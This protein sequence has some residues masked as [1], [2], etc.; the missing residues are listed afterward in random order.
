MKIINACQALIAGEMRSNVAITIQENIITEIGEAVDNPDDVV[1]GTLIPGFVD[2]HS[3]GGGGSSF[4]TTDEDEI[5]RVIATHRL[6][7]TTSHVASLVTAPI[8]VLKD[9]IA[10]LTPFVQSGKL[11]GI[12][13]EGP[14]LSREKCG[15]HDP[16]ILRTPDLDEIGDLIDHGDGTIIM[17]TIAP[18]L[19]NAIAAIEMM[20]DRGVVVAIGHS[21]ANF[22]ITQAAIAA[23][24][25]VVTHFYSAMPSLNHREQNLMS[26]TLLDNSMFLELILD[27]IHVNALAVEIL[28]KCAP[29]RVMLVTDAMS[30]AGFHDGLYKIGELDVI[31][32]NGVA[33]L[34]SNGSLAGSTLTMDR[35]FE[36]LISKHNYSIAQA[37]FATSTLPARALGIEYVGE[38]SVGKL[39]NFVK[40]V[41]SKVSN[42]IFPDNR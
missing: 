4:T 36:R 31:V 25:S 16:A 20:V 42:D 23:G 19:P 1:D 34:I 38:I 7:G 35:A 40:V 22:E 6:H 3:H 17:V 27:G 37:S 24:A 41:D 30:A 29:D 9:Q 8:N 39:A 21:N 33:R 10:A 13:L 18:E 26:A 28:L 2:I 12:H 15:A 5:E 11:I 32:K 14:Y